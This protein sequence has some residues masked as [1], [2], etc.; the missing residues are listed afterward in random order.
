MTSSIDHRRGS[1]PTLIWLWHR[2]AATA[3]I[4]PLAYE[5]PYTAGLA[6]KRKKKKK[7]EKI[8]TEIFMDEVI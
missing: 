8:D 2:L 3:P 5:L 7:K 1:D 4:Q 6:L